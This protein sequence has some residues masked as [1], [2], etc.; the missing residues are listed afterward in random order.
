V[1]SDEDRT[2]VVDR[3]KETMCFG[4]VNMSISH[5]KYVVFETHTITCIWWLCKYAAQA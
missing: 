1:P 4:R 2:V 3:S 5:K